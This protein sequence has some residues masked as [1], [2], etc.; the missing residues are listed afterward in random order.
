MNYEK[1]III[2]NNSMSEAVYALDSGSNPQYS[3]YL[4]WTNQ[5]SGSHADLEGEVVTG[6]M[7]GDY[8]KVTCTFIGK[9]KIVSWGGYSAWGNCTTT[10]NSITFVRQGHFNANEN[11]SFSF[12]NVVFDSGEVT[13]DTHK[14]SYYKSGEHI[15]ES[16]L[17]DGTW[18]IDVSF[19]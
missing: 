3:A 7:T 14:G 18:T 16:A 11:L 1:P 17:T 8:M 15:Q 2:E 12:N 5:N 4:R 10:D 9:G 19:T 13:D 6:N